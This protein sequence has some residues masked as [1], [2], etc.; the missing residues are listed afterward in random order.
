MDF[1]NIDSA[2]YGDDA[3]DDEL[4]AELLALENEEEQKKAVIKPTSKI[5]FLVN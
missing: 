1:S 4:M 3:D 5:P 2:I